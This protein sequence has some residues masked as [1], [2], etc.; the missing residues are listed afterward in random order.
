MKVNYLDYQGHRF[1]YL[2]EGQGPTV[3]VLGG[4]AYY[5]QT[6]SESIKKKFRFIYLDH[7]G[8]AE[9]LVTQD[10]LPSMKDLVEDIEFF[11]KEQGLKDFFLLGHSGHAYL[12]MEYAREYEEQVKGLMIIA[13]GPDLSLKNRKASDQYFEEI[14]DELRKRE[15]EKNLNLMQKEIAENP[16]EEFKIFCIRSAARSS[17][18]PTLDVTPYW[19][20]VHLNLDIVLHMWSQ[21]FS[22]EIE[23]KKIE[24]LNRPVL[25]IMGLFDFQVPPHYTWNKYKHNFQN[26]TF[27]VFPRSG[28]HPQLEES[29]L[30]ERVVSDWIDLGK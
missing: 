29:E 28:H 15:H 10:S 23:I 4:P 3:L 8:F 21:L 30:F 20:E 25:I 12:A 27:K 9:R 18:D 11:R 16:K 24:A 26:L 19:K 13:A 6:F 7:R 17:F 5:A 2:L 14:A 22:Q 1:T